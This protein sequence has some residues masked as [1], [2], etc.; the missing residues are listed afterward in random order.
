[1]QSLM[2]KIFSGNGYVPH[3]HCYL[4]QPELVSFHVMADLLIAIA[5]FSIPI[6][7]LYFVQKR[8][9]VPFSRIF[10]LFSLF[11]VSCGITHLV[12]IVTL[13]YPLYW[14]SGII[15]IFCAIISLLTAFELSSVIPLALALPSPEKLNKINIQL[16]NE[17]KERKKIEAKLI[18][19]N[20]DLK[21]SNEELEQFAY[22]ASHDLQEPLRTITS[23]AEILIEEYSAQFE[24]TARE[25]LTYI[26]SSSQKM[27]ILI[28]DL[29]R[30]SKV[31]QQRRQFTIVDL[32]E[33]VQESIDLVIPSYQDI[34]I[35]LDVQILP[36]IKGDRV[37]LIHLWL[38][39]ISNALKFN[40]NEQIEIKIGVENQESNWLFYIKDNGIGISLEYQEKIFTIF[41]RLHCQDEYEGTGIGLALCQK[42]IS[43]HGG[44][45]WVKSELDKGSTFYFTMPK[46][47]ISS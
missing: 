6:T 16:E 40:N 11:I 30:L 20:R 4:W 17:I 32:N 12:A 14:L 45:I 31:S 18:T 26:A 25:Y 34:N 42:I 9:D 41:Q 39:L 5:Y 19:S 38:N 36:E 29:L 47:L 2:E 22:V 21:R 44:K 7:L 15:K 35:Q 27:K 3:G 33:I 43:R 28:K 23:F 46:N 24:E 10:I 37:Q 13:W 1:M 8:E